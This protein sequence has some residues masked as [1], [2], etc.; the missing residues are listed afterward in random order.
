MIAVQRNFNAVEALEKVRA[1]REMRRRRVTWGKSRLGKHRAE[2]AK[3]KA[4]G[5][6]LNDLVFWLRKEKRVRVC[7]ST[8]QRFLKKIPAVAGNG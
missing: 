6:S 3:M 1:A 8:V 4:S 2:L 7:A 5:G